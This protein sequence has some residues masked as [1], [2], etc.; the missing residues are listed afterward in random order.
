MSHFINNRIK[1]FKHAFNGLYEGFKNETHLKIHLIAT[2]IVTSSGFYFNLKPFEW[3]AI[4]TCCALVIAAELFNSAV[5]SLCNLVEPNINPKIKYIK[6]ICA[7][8]VL[9]MSIL[10]LIVACIIFIPYVK[11]L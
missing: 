8:A 5:E 1:A 11:H 4:I 3:F 9:V 10:S 7:A 2:I 6:D